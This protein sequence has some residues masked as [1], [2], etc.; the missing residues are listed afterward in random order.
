[1]FFL[2]VC[3]ALLSL[4]RTRSPR[5]CTSSATVLQSLGELFSVRCT[6][7]RDSMVVNGDCRAQEAYSAC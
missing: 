3:R 4:Y 5:C 6:K 1:M 2:A 7:E